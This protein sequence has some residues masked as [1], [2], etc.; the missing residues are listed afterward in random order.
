MDKPRV[1]YNCEPCGFTTDNKTDYE[2]HLTRKKHILK[3]MPI[4]E[5]PSSISNIYSLRFLKS[6]KRSPYLSYIN[7]VKDEIIRIKTSN[8]S[9]VESN[10]ES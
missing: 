2:R 3:T 7:T 1:C 8:L 6:L 4:N 5:H 10:Q 9:M